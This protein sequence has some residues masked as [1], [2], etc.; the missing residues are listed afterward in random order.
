MLK[1]MNKTE[2]LLKMVKIIKELELVQ[3]DSVIDSELRQEYDILNEK[4]KDIILVEILE[5]ID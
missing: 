1:K 2:I 4:L 3:E 5:P